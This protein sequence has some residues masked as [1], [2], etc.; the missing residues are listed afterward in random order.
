MSSL[1][2]NSN[3]VTIAEISALPCF[4]NGHCQISALTKGESHLCFKVTFSNDGVENQYFVKSLTEHQLTSQA[5]VNSHLSAAENG[6]A[7]PVIF[8]SELWLISEFIEGFSL[9]QFCV[10]NPKFSL[11]SKITVAMSL[12]AKNHQLK[13]SAE[14]LVINVVELLT[15]QISPKIYTQEQKVELTNIIKSI[16]SFKRSNTDLILCHGDLNDDNIRL[17]SEFESNQLT[18]K[19]WLVD[20]ECSS[21]SEPEYDVAMF[22]AINQLSEGN[23]SEVIASYQQYSTLILNREKVRDY[24]ACCYLINGLWYLEARSNSKQAKAFTAKARCQFI[25]FD[26]LELVNQKVA[27]LLKQLLAD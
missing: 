19:I 6:F 20:F 26:Q 11:A 10:N 24:L 3:K 15:S 23:I 14:H 25:L 17:S 18:E 8:Y 22:L 12:M 7:P 4:V 21:L 1:V 13:A 16:T 5:E 27:H 2:I 9:Q